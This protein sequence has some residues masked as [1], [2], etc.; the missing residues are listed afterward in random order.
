VLELRQEFLLADLLHASGLPRSTYYYQVKT[1]A[2]P[3]RYG[4]LKA[5]IQAVYAAHRGLYGY[6]RVT[7]AIRSDG[8]LVN[9]K[10]VQRLMNELGIRSRVR[11]KKFRSYQGEVGEAAPNLLNR[12]FTASRPNEKWVTDVTEFRVAGKKLYLSPVMDLYNGEI[13]A[14][15]SSHRPDFPMVMGMLHKAV[16]KRGGVAKPLLHSDSK[17]TG[18]RCFR[19]VTVSKKGCFRERSGAVE[20]SGRPDPHSD[21]LNVFPWTRRSSGTAERRGFTSSIRVT[22][23]GPDALS[24]Y[25]LVQVL[26]AGEIAHTPSATGARL[27]ERR[28]GYCWPSQRR[29]RR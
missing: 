29:R 10:K 25:C 20:R 18:T 7:L 3:D 4:G 17:N 23:E 21:R 12:E 13:V 6:R 16:K 2:A 1:L 11:R 22:Q 27:Y 9:H 28:T 19:A 26:D 8:E 5:K 24:L 15:E 14:Y